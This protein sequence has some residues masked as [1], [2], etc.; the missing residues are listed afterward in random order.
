MTFVQRRIFKD[1]SIK[2]KNQ[3]NRLMVM[4]AV[5]TGELARRCRTGRSRGS[6]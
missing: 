1:V 4:E 3:E 5:H 6:F 2:H